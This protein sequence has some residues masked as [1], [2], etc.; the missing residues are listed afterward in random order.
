MYSPNR[1]ESSNSYRYGFQGQ[2]LDNEIKGE[3]NSINYKYR[4]H[5]PRIGRFFAVDPLTS[6]YPH[7]TPYSFSGNKVIHAIELEG[8]E[9][10]TI[11]D[12]PIYKDVKLLVVTNQNV[13]FRVIDENGVVMNHFKYKTLEYQMEGWES[14][15]DGSIYVPR[16][17]KENMMPFS[18]PAKYTYTNPENTFTIHNKGNTELNAIKDV[19]VEYD[20]NI[21][22]VFERV[23]PIDGAIVKGFTAPESSTDVKYNISATHM[24]A[25]MSG[26]YSYDI[27]V[28]VY[29]SEGE[30]VTSTKP[31]GDLLFSMKPGEEFTIKVDY[32]DNEKFAADIVL[33]G[34]STR[35]E[36]KVVN[37]YS[38][39]E[40]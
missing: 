36:K 23:S 33:N 13:E 35:T 2:E 9:E 20:K 16:V 1:H 14:R 29:N 4:M 21:D 38:S 10:F 39:D 37:D 26:D 3:G 18:E 31:G 34:S 30:L 22:N 5:D 32:G 27:T 6:K 8:L 11:I 17:P 12:H 25:E 19:I 15:P 24:L 40:D 7:Y 28:S